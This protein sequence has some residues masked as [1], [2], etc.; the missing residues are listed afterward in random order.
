[1]Y[2][3][4]ARDEEDVAGKTVLF[5]EHFEPML[6]KLEAW[7][8][9]GQVPDH[10]SEFEQYLQVCRWPFRK[11]E[12]SFALDIL[13]EHLKPGD[14]YLDAG[15]G[16]TPLSQVIAARGVQT[17]ACD[18]D[19][20]LIEYLRVVDTR[21]IYGSQVTFSCQDLTHT[22]FADATFDAISCI[23]VLEH[24]PA[25]LDRLAVIELLRILKPGGILVLTVD[26]TPPASGGQNG[27]VKRYFQRAFTLAR[28]GSV[29]EIGRGVARKIRAW[30]TVRGGM[31]H[32]ARSANQC[33]EVSHLEQDIVPLLPDEELST[34]IPFSRDVC[35]VDVDQAYRFWHIGGLYDADATRAVL[36]VA[37]A[38]RKPL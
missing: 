4:Y 18:V 30:Q 35:S 15:C 6:Q 34:R 19:A 31:A 2:L 11:L 38:V 3:L 29:V 10:I 23:S 27:S 22:T 21:R 37:I 8:R 33:F 17:D 1:M 13:I 16:V 7:V 28:H 9:E 25:G 14:R 32:V 36:P 5:E 26:Y 12:Y 20:R 24:I